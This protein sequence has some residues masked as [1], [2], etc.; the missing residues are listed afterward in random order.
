MT[1]DTWRTSPEGTR[2][3]KYVRISDGCWEWTGYR[4]AKGYGAA[5]F[6]GRKSMPAH[7]AIYVLAVGAVADGLVLDHLCRNRACVNPAH[8]EVVTNR[9]NVLRGDTLPAKFA[10]R[11][12]CA[13]GHPFTPE[14]TARRKSRGDSRKCRTCENQW[15]REC[16]ARKRAAAR[17]EIL[18]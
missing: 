15:I 4:N 7:R 14:N 3:L 17:V 5:Y 18:S 9:V 12:H 10:A 8:L 6:R 13:K 1:T 2:L 16:R 11:T